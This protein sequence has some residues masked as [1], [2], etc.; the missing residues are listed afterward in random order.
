MP[1]EQY[2]TFSLRLCSGGGLITSTAC[3]FANDHVRLLSPEELQQV[4]FHT[5]PNEELQLEQ[6]VDTTSG[7]LSS[8]RRTESTKDTKD[9][10]ESKEQ[11]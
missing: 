9:S 7:D 11:K 2:E 3:L 6:A 8:N 10:K 5:Q 1:I 4:S